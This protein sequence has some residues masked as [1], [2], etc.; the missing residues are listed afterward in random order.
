MTVVCIHTRTLPRKFRSSSYCTFLVFTT[1]KHL[2]SS[3]VFS[4]KESLMYSLP[5][6]FT[7]ISYT[8]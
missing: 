3:N 5:M 1:Y 4:V 7:L 8:I 2:D 6:L